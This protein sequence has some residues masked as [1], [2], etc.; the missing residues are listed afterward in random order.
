M[1]CTCTYVH[2]YVYVYVYVC[3]YVCVY[4]VLA[5]LSMAVLRVLWLYLVHGSHG[6]EHE[7][8][9]GIDRSRRCRHPC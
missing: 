2:V 5:P 9:G 3:V 6:A 7:R 4:N 8:A 1:H